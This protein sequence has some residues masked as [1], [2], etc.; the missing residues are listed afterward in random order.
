MNESITFAEYSVAQKAEGKNLLLRILL[1]SSYVLLSLGFFIF[2][3]MVFKIVM[4]ISILP[5]LI[6]ILVFFTWRFAAVEH[7]YQVAS[8]TITFSD[9][10]GGRSRKKKFEY[11][12]KD[13]QT[14]A[15]M[16]RTHE[17]DYTH[18]TLTHDFRGSTKSPDSYYFTYK[19]DA[20]ENCVVYFEATSRTLKTFRYY[21]S[22]AT[23]MSTSLR[24]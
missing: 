19:N 21:N 1:I 20:G 5:L 6:W 3:T 10:Y 23:V 15:P 7:E 24:Y 18:A 8:G 12:I 11:K 13:M 14:I 22:A 17:S 4:L 9:V 16:D 2:F